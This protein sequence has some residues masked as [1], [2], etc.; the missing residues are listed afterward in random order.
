ICP[1]TRADS[2]SRFASSPTARTRTN[3]GD[4]NMVRNLYTTHRYESRGRK[5]TQYLRVGH[6]EID[7]SKDDI[8]GRVVVAGLEKVGPL[9]MVKD[10]PREEQFSKVTISE[11][12][13]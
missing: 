12:K 9:V 3:K 13:P 4:K 11:V 8:I 7:L 2:S 6:V 10:E 1:V 5:H